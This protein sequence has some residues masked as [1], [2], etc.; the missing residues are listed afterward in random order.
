MGCGSSAT[1]SNP[2]A[3]ANTK[4]PGIT[5]EITVM[6]FEGAFARASV[7]VHLFEYVGQ[8]WKWNKLSQEKYGQMCA[9]GEMG[10]FGKGLPQIQVSMNGKSQQMAQTNAILRSFGM[11]YGLYDP[12]DWKAARYCDQVVE[13]NGD[14]I[15][16]CFPI[17]GGGPIEPFLAVTKKFHNMI[18]KN[19]AHHGGKYVAG[20]KITIAD[21]TTC[22]YISCFIKNK[23]P[24]NKVAAPNAAQ[25]SETPR[26]AEYIER[27]C[28]EFPYILNRVVE[29]PY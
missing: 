13:T 10:E 3:Q 28:K 29:D 20:N 9:A 16:A 5:S 11:R 7:L 15:G 24:G 17:L 19:L 26:F 8:P 6:Y 1:A 12:R 2:G 23:H 27:M 22:S 18:E 25:L 14:V 4:R 21:I